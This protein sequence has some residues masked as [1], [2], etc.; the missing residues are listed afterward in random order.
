MKVI[1][2]TLKREE[3]GIGGKMKTSLINEDGST[4][5]G[6]GKMSLDK[7]ETILP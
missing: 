1:K 5:M 3:Q 7:G 2:G 4:T 6:V